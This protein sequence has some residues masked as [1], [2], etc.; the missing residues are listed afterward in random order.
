[1]PNDSRNDKTNKKKSEYDHIA[2]TGDYPFESRDPYNRHVRKGSERTKGF[3]GT[4]IL[5]PSECRQW[6]KE[7]IAEYNK[8]MGY[9][10][11]T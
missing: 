8:M 10:V 4:K 2:I 9:N 6:T 5:P 1:M 11:S 7:E 3:R